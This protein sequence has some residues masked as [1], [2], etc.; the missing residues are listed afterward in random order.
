[1]DSNSNKNQ[2]KNIEKQSITKPISLIKNNKTTK[3]DKI[4]NNVKKKK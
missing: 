2:E 4:I 1:M 3:K